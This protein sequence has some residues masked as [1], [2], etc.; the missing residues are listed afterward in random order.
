MEA[1]LNYF[2]KWSHLTFQLL[3]LPCCEELG[4]HRELGGDTT[5]T[6]DPDWPKR[7]QTHCMRLCSAIKSEGK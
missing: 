7:E 3:T 2:R 6:A 1:I 5:S 4:V